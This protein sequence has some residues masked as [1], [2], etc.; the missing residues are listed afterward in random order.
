MFQNSLMRPTIIAL[1]L[2][3]LSYGQFGGGVLAMKS[4]GKKADNNAGVNAAF[5]LD[6]SEDRTFGN[7]MMEQFWHPLG[8]S[9][10]TSSL[11]S[12]CAAEQ[13]AGSNGLIR[14]HVQST[15]ETYTLRIRAGSDE[16]NYQLN[17]NATVTIDGV[18]TFTGGGDFT[19]QF[20]TAPLV[21]AGVTIDAVEN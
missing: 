16:T 15:T 17:G 20:S 21:L 9:G 13:T 19:F 1:L 7:L 12:E 3:G 11:M 2:T 10:R 5:I 6:S 8:V 4:A 18:G 14:F